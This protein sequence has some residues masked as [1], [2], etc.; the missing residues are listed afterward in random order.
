MDQHSDE[1][2]YANVKG[3][4]PFR[5]KRVRQALYQA[6]DIDAINKTVMRGLS[7]PTG[8]MLPNAG[9]STPELEKR[10]PYDKAAAK[11]LLVDAGYPNGFE[12]TLDCP[13]NRYVND[14][15]ICQA[16]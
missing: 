14:E 3:K 5:D 2:A 16:L 1:L 10:L 4:N 8:V 15:K 11:K 13:N 12:V 6:I 7:T 9:Q